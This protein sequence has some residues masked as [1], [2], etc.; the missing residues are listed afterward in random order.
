[1]SHNPGKKKK[2]QKPKESINRRNIIIIIIHIG[3]DN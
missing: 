1:M 3:I 2:T